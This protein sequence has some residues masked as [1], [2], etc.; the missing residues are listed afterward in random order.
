MHDKKN[1]AFIHQDFPGGGAEI[2]T[3]DIARML[4]P[5]DVK[6]YVFVHNLKE[7]KIPV[8]ATNINII[9]LEH[10]KDKNNLH[11]LINE[12][13]E[14]NIGLF[15]FPGDVYEVSLYA[16]EI[17][18]KTG[19]KSIFMLH[20][21]PFWEYSIRKE[22]IKRDIKRSFSKRLEWYFLRSYKYLL[23][24]KKAKVVK[25]YKECYDKVD[26]FGVLCESY[27]REIATAI[28]EVYENSKFRVLTNSLITPKSITEKKQKEIYYVGRLNYEFKRVDRLLK[29]WSVIEDKHPD[30]SLNIVGEGE[31]SSNLKQI[32]KRE[33]L[34]R[35][36]FIGFTNNPKQYYD[37]ASI[38]CMTSTYE[39]WGMVLME[40][41]ANRC[42]VMAFDC[43]AGVR[44][45]LS[46]SWE[47][48]VLIKPFDIDAYAKALSRLIT[49]TD[50]REKIVMNGSE[51]VKRFSLENTLQ[52][53][54]SVFNELSIE[55]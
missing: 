37:R 27:G 1:I 53:W 38:V 44:E 54:N 25:A 49:D 36:N 40:A 39:G 42:A 33:G 21:Q 11:T 4:E 43:S 28:G 3:F 50:L 23:G 14:K 46:P 29:V 2:V 12:I 31:E 47:N 41:Q 8:N 22:I 13:K 10:Y 16:D 17:R 7:E 26:I 45:I 19:C 55:E 9:K 52:Q 20:S 48:G 15:V 24:I 5:K 18:Q 32:A 6:V 30:W 51:S 34:K 35:V